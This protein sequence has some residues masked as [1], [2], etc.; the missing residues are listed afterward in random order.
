MKA[1]IMLPIV[2]ISCLAN[3]KTVS[4][5]DVIKGY[6]SAWNA[7]NAEKAATYFS[8]DVQYYDVTVGKS[9]VGQVNAKDHVIKVFIDAVPNLKWKMIGQPIIGQDGIAFEWEFSGKNTGTWA[10]AAPTNKDISFKGVSFVHIHHGKITY[11]GDYYDAANLNHQ[12]GL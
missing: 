7:H 2:L 5:Q 12:L 8:K 9:E 11:Q 1:L 4:P 6:M 10:G 3:A